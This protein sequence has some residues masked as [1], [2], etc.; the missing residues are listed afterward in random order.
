[1]VNNPA[2]DP[3]YKQVSKRVPALSDI[4]FK[5]PVANKPIHKSFDNGLKKYFSYNP[6]VIRS[7]IKTETSL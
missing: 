2:F 6:S 5:R 1:M 7:N 4:D 3:K